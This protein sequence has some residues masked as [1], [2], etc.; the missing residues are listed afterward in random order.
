MSLSLSSPQ[1][2]KSSKIFNDNKNKY[3]FWSLSSWKRRDSKVPQKKKSR[4]KP[5]LKWYP[6]DFI[7]WTGHHI[8]TVANQIEGGIC[9]WSPDVYHLAREKERFWKSSSFM[10]GH[11]LWWLCISTATQCIGY[12]ILVKAC[13][14]VGITR[15]LTNLK[16]KCFASF[17]VWRAQIWLF[18]ALRLRQSTLIHLAKGWVWL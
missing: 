17:E 18:I 6:R 13:L 4:Q 15:D 9:I 2:V 3:S 14:R 16:L 7:G 1:K 8:T 10:F 5:L 11:L 12:K